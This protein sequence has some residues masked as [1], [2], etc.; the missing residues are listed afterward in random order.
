[1]RGCARPPAYTN[2]IVPTLQFHGTDELP[3][4]SILY[5]SKAETKTKKK[6]LNCPRRTSDE[7]S[8]LSRLVDWFAPAIAPPRMLFAL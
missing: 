2:L 8:G 1:M 4:S 6:K 5:I 3:R 7:P